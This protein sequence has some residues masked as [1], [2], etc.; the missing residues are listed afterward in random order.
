MNAESLVLHRISLAVGRY[1]NAAIEA[2]TFYDGKVKTHALY[3]DV[4][5]EVLRVVRTAVRDGLRGELAPLLDMDKL[6]DSIDV[7]KAQAAR[8]RQL[9]NEKQRLADRLNEI[10]GLINAESR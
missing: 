1:M 3:W 4:T 9:E 6:V 8:I 7:T 10:S 5:Q 2:H